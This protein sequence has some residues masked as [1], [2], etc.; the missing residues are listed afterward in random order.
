MPPIGA[1][2]VGFESEDLRSICNLR[3]EV[4]SL[5]SALLIFNCPFL[6]LGATIPA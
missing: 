1:D 3:F 6:R 4:H 2:G 5:G